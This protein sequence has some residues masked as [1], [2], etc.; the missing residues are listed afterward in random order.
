MAHHKYIY[1]LLKHKV[2]KYSSA[3]LGNSEIQGYPQDISGIYPP[4]TLSTLTSPL[5]GAT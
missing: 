1:Y 4:A 2:C 3:S 5:S